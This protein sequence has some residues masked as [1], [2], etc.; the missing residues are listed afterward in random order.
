M[1]VNYTACIDIYRYRDEAH[2]FCRYTFNLQSNFLHIFA[3]D[4]CVSFVYKRYRTYVSM[5]LYQKSFIRTS[6]NLIWEYQNIYLICIF[7]MC[8]I[9]YKIYKKTNKKSK[10]KK[11]KKNGDFTV[12]TQITS[13]SDRYRYIVDQLRDKKETHPSSLTY[14]RVL[15]SRDT[16]TVTTTTTTTT[17]AENTGILFP[18]CCTHTSGR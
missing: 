8:C 17:I 7:T 18:G 3:C 5:Y 2:K 13:I 14:W 9:S 6:K 12:V 10:K 15:L 1:H 16:T 4:T 11:K